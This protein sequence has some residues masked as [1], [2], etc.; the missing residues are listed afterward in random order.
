[1]KKAEILRKKYPQFIYENYSWKV[2]K[3]DLKIFFLFKIEPSVEFRPEITIKNIDKKRVAEAGDCVLNNLIFHIG[4]IEM[5]SY[6]KATCSPEIIIKAGH[7]NDNQIKWWHDIIINGMGQYFFENKINFT[8]PNFLKIISESDNAGCRYEKEFQEKYLVPIGGGKDSIVTLEKLL[9]KP[10]RGGSALG[11][12]ATC[13]LVNPFISALKVVKVSGSGKPIIIERKL[14]PILLKMNADSLPA[15]RQGFLN[16]HIPFTALLSFL[17]VLSAVLFD[18]KFVVFSNEKSAN[19]GNVEYLG[20]TINHQWSKSS[21]FE[22]KFKEYCKKYLAKNISYSSFLRNYTELEISKMFVQLPKYFSFFSSCNIVKR[23]KN[24]VIKNGG[25]GKWCGECPKCLFVYITLYPFL[26]QKEMLKIFGKDL[27][28]DEKLL[29]L[30]KDL[31]GEGKL[32]PFECV[33]TFAET[34]IALQLGLQKA[35]KEAK[36]GRADKIPYLLQN[37]QYLS[38]LN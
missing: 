1:M 18:F 2:I 36:L 16:G 32:K 15:G 26:P 10:A 14:D 9:A 4:L 29:P 22:K 13:F 3:N 25:R 17:G 31:M 8:V 11:G 12:K 33:G 37:I 35:K 20:K 28:E 27:Y 6:W 23:M 38:K 24:A 19:E 5:L 34:K 21:E 7:L 30:M